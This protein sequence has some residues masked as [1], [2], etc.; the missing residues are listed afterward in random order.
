MKK[1]IL[2]AVV[3]IGIGGVP[4]LAADLPGRTYAPAAPFVAPVYSW[5][6]FYIGGNIGYGS[7]RSSFSDPGL[8]NPPLSGPSGGE[9]ATSVVGG[10]QI[11]YNLQTGA[12][13]FGAQGTFDGTGI[14]GSHVNPLS[15]PPLGVGGDILGTKTAWFATQTA[16]FGYTVTPQ[17]LLYVKGGAAEARFNY[18]DI[19]S[20]VSAGSPYSGTG[21]STRFGWTVG[22]GL[23]Y[24][25]TSNWSVFAEYNYSDF[26]T[27]QTLFT[28][29]APNPANAT[30]YV[31][32]ETNRLQTVLVGVNYRFGFGSPV[33]ARY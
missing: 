21:S 14:S 4:A 19:D 26:R 18:T 31:Y 1:N 17:A 5:T 22:A 6:G 3:S 10:G 29:T 32:K 7:Q 20:I 30:P 13:V 25:P 2:G 28:Y 23:E 12:W 27:A 8:S 15:Q 24:A 11:G 9:T 33:V 16:R